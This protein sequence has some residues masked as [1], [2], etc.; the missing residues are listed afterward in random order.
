MNLFNANKPLHQHLCKPI[1]K[2]LSNIVYSELDLSVPWNRLDK[3]VALTLRLDI[4]LEKFDVLK[5]MARIEKKLDSANEE[6]INEGLREA[7]RYQ[8]TEIK[9]WKK[10]DWKDFEYKFANAVR[11]YWSSKFWLVN[12]SKQWGRYDARTGT[13]YFPSIEC[14]TKLNILKEKPK[15]GSI[16]IVGV[17]NVAEGHTFRSSSNVLDTQDFVEEN[18]DFREKIAEIEKRSIESV[19]RDYPSRIDLPYIEG[20]HEIGHML[21]LYHPNVGTADCPTATTDHV[22]CYGS[23]LHQSR[24]V[25]G[26]GTE[27]RKEHA[28]PWLDALKLYVNRDPRKDWEI[29]LKKIESIAVKRR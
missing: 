20:V 22:T 23:T 12:K 7:E 10:K 5:D 18:R 3:A 28:K 27:I 21:G 6:I 1:G 11:D 24:S 17:V 4:Y 8:N 29:S 16:N 19:K 25:M 15:K 14:L 26:R 9:K 13:E 2:R